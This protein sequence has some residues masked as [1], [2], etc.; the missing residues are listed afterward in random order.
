MR[1]SDNVGTEMRNALDVSGVFKDVKSTFG[2]SIVERLLITHA[3]VEQKPEEPSKQEGRVVCELTVTEEMLNGAGTIHGGCSA[4]IID[5]G[6]S[7]A[8]MALTRG[9]H[10]SQSLNIV[11]HSPAALLRIINTTMTVGARAMSVRTEIWNTTHHRMVASA[12]HVKMKP[13]LSKL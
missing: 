3:S 4:L 6:S 11:Y 8:L 5:V 12:V 1:F 7:L 9:M 13:S 2:A 10:V